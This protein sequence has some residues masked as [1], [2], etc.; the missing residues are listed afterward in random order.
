MKAPLET[1][2]LMFYLAVAEELHFR[3]AAERLRIA[4]PYLTTRIRRLEERL[5]LRLLDRTTRSVRMTPAGEKFYERAK[6]AVSQIE[7]AIA[8]T[9]LVAAGRAGQL[10]I[11]FTPAAA[12]DILPRLLREL[13]RAHPS[14]GVSLAYKETAPQIRELVEGKLHFGFLRLPV[15]TRRLNT[16]VLAREGVVAALPADDRLSQ[17]R[18]LRLEQLAGRNLIQFRPLPGVDFQEH[19]TS[20]CNRAGFSP[21]AVQDVSDTPS[22][23]ALVAAGFGVAILPGWV[24]QWP[25][26]GVVFKALREIPPVVDLAVAWLAEP[27]SPAMQ[28]F[29]AV[30]KDHHR[31]Q[32]R[33]GR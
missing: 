30:I 10:S 13:R 6:Y 29:L 33:G 8:S 12:F 17:R 4:Q 5:G 14:I 11:G 3:R 15:H 7:D 32:K 21:P 23:V 27:P 18:S 1:R 9:K 26:P 24:Q 31:T 28:S 22:A 25:H 16:L 2:E 19:V 20:Y